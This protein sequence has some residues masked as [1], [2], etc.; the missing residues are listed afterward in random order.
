MARD[1]AV[2]YFRR[3]GGGY[4]KFAQELEQ[5]KTD[6]IT[7]NQANIRRQLW[8]SYRNARDGTPLSKKSPGVNISE[9][10]GLCVR[11][12]EAK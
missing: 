3:R 6:G 9:L 1:S 11:T 5:L 2:K 7:V 12:K 4:T 8:H 10:F